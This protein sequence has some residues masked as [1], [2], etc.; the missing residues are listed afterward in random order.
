MLQFGSYSRRTR[1]EEFLVTWQM[2]AAPLSDYTLKDPSALLSPLFLCVFTEFGSIKDLGLYVES[3]ASLHLLI[4]GMFR[5][6]ASAG[7]VMLYPCNSVY[8]QFLWN[9]IV[10]FG[11]ILSFL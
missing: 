5:G 10:D 2:L 4:S 11:F 3:G 9:F 7:Y 8:V 1:V 6:S